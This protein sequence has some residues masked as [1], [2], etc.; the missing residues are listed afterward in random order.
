MGICVGSAGISPKILARQ[1]MDRYSTNYQGRK[2][3]DVVAYIQLAEDRKLQICLKTW[4]YVALSRD[5]S[6]DL[7]GNIGCFISLVL[8]TSSHGIFLG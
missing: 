5:Y 6:L 7:N 4:K 1:L 2:S 8:G 3:N